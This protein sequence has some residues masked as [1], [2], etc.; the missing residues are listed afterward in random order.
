MEGGAGLRLA[1][2]PRADQPPL[3]VAR[4]LKCSHVVFGDNG[5]IHGV[6]W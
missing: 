3:V 4:D 6:I 2:I 1:P 5:P